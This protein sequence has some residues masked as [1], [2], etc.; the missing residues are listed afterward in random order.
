MIRIP[1]VN[2]FS[3]QPAFK[4]Q[5]DNTCGCKVFTKN[6]KYEKADMILKQIEETLQE[7]LFLKYL[8]L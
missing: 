1:S 7:S 5:K 3:F 8:F 6:G 4:V 2:L